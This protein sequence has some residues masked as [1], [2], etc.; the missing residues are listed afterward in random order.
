MRQPIN[1]LKHSA[2]DVRRGDQPLFIDNSH[3]KTAA[4]AFLLIFTFVAGIFVAKLHSSPDMHTQVLKVLKE[5][6]LAFQTLVEPTDMD[7]DPS[8]LP[9]VNEPAQVQLYLAEPDR[10]FDFQ[11]VNTV[12]LADTQ[13]PW[14]DCLIADRTISPRIW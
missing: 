5:G 12:C 14:S 1:P 8:I 3:S 13:L 10:H 2:L 11:H 4:I 9:D 7:A 6:K